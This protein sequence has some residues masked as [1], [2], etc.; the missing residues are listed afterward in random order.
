MSGNFYNNGQVCSNCTRV[1]VD[2]SI[3]NEFLAEFKRRVGE[4]IDN[5]SIGS[6]VDE[7]TI[8]GPIVTEQHQHRIANHIDK[9]KQDSSNTLV[10]GGN[11]YERNGGFYVEPTIFHCSRDGAD[12]VREVSER[13]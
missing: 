11:T 6:A 4:I 10:I 7:K 2:E 9:A 3:M 12:I 8:I 13:E 1:F 5:K